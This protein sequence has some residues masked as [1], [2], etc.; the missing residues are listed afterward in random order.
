MFKTATEKAMERAETEGMNYDVKQVTTYHF[1]VMHRA[2]VNRNY[3][4]D[5]FGRGSCTCKAWEKTGVCKHQ[6]MTLEALD[7]I[8]REEAFNARADYD[9]YAKY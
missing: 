8:R 7:L 9:A 2:D 3:V 1:A 6:Y 5:T 4:V